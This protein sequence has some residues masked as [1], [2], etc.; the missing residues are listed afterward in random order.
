MLES[1][2]PAPLSSK[3]PTSLQVEVLKGIETEIIYNNC[4]DH[5]IKRVHDEFIRNMTLDHFI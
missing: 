2:A 4:N 1:N 5:A 3:S